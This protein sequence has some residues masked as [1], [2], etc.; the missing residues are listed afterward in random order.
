MNGLDALI[1]VLI[2]VAVAVGYRLG[3]VTRLVSW[4]GL[5]AGAIIAYRLVP[6]FVDPN[7]ASSSTRTEVFAELGL[8]VGL[9]LV[10]QAVG[11]FVAHRA[12]RRPSGG[13]SRVERAG[14]AALGAF[15]V[16]VLVWMLPALLPVAGW[17]E[18]AIRTSSIVRVVSEVAPDQPEALRA[19]GRRIADSDFSAILDPQA[20]STDPGPAPTST[21]GDE[22]DARIRPSVVKVEGQAC[23]EIQDGSGFVVK[24]GLVI[25]NAHVVAGETSTRVIDNDGNSYEARVVGFDPDRD[26][27]VLRVPSLRAAAIPL[28][29]PTIG[30]TGAVYGF[31]GGGGLR[32]APARVASQVVAVGRDI[33]DTTDTRRDVLIL[34]A[35]LAPGDSGAAL[36]TPAGTA[37]GVAFAIDPQH[38]A[39]GYALTTGEVRAVLD[40]VGTTPVGTGSCTHG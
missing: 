15:G 36:V 5:V 33:Y 30:D 22:V 26:L 23:S 28:A 35:S 40:F 1:A 24:P 10:G 7:H 14:G 19:L 38:P 18:P 20:R 8:V 32:P 9:A 39:T 21:L 13:I 34:A 11:M 29:A 25:T 27:A 6:G 16:L 4:V 2:V 37:I 31:P 12:L 17:P 3:F